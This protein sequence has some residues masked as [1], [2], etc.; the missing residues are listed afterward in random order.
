[1]PQTL[2]S[3]VLTCVTIRS[4]LDRVHLTLKDY[5]GTTR[6]S[7]QN[8]VDQFEGIKI[9]CAIDL[10][11]LETHVSALLDV[12]IR[13]VPLI[14][15]NTSTMAKLKALYNDSDMKELFRRLTVYVTLLNTIQNN[16]QRS[17]HLTLRGHD[18]N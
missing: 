13:D 15:Q 18:L 3:I 2:S 12:A 10:S 11:L 6:D 17:V 16:L 5:S 8:L 1:M 14:A 7:H 4:S 9:A